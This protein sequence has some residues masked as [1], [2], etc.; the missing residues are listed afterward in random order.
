MPCW[1]SSKQCLQCVSESVVHDMPKKLV[2]VGVDTRE[3][4]KRSPEGDEMFARLVPEVEGGAVVIFLRLAAGC[5]SRL[6]ISNRSVLLKKEP[7]FCGLWNI[8]GAV[9]G[10][11]V[12]QMS[13]KRA[14]WWW[15]WLVKFKTGGEKIS[16]FGGETFDRVYRNCPCNAK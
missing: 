7:S 1:Y 6:L 10:T 2:N 8:C 3:V 16:S 9:S 12:V 4:E 11:C 15:W 13:Q 14:G 5:S